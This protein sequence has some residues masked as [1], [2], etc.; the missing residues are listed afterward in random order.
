MQ[1]FTSKKQK[2][3]F[4]FNEKG[5][6]ISCNLD[7]K[8]YNK[9]PINQTNSTNVNSLLSIFSLGYSNNYDATQ[10]EESQAKKFKKKKGRKF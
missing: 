3:V 1:Q 4:Q 5:N 6:N 2:E 9:Y 10:A 7:S 8:Q